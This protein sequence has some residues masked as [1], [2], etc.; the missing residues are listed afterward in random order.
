MFFYFFKIIFKIS[1]LKRSKNIKKLFFLKTRVGSYFQTISKYQSE[2]A[3]VQAW[4]ID[5]RQVWNRDS[6]YGLKCFFL[7]NILK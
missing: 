6:G 4:E 7:K 3:H 2:D 5:L 1:T